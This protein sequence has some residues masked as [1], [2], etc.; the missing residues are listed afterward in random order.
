MPT[1]IERNEVASAVAVRLRL[2][3]ERRLLSQRDLA[4][5]AGV[6]Q[7]TIVNIES[8]RNRPHPS[9]L[10]RLAVALDVGPE[11]LL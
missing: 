10:R 9:T 5:L 8:G 6:S 7:T 11:A 4:A 2:L 3:R 1:P